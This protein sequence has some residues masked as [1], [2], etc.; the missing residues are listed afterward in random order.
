MMLLTKDRC[1]KAIKAKKQGILIIT[2]KKMLSAYM[3]HVQ[4]SFTV[5]KLSCIACIA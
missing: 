2:N 4:Y 5:L 1:K 3:I